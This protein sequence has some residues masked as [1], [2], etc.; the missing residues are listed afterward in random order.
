MTKAEI[1]DLAERVLRSELGS[2]GLDRIDI[3]EDLDN[4]DDPALFVDAFLKAGSPPVAGEVST[5]VHHALS[6]KLLEAG[7]NRFPYLRVRHPD[8]EEPE[9]DLPPEMH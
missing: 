2:L 7:E 5:H 4:S 9:G 1:R 8:D 6:R 3:R